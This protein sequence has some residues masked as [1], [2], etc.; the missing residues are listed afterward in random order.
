MESPSSNQ[1]AMGVLHPEGNVTC[2]LYVTLHCPFP[3]LSL[4]KEKFAPSLIG[5]INP[6]SSHWNNEEMKIAYNSAYIQIETF[7]FTFAQQ[8]VIMYFYL[9]SNFQEIAMLIA[10]Y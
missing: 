7:N 6:L 1:S 9:C 2:I 10:K 4:P 8:A 3:L 5:D